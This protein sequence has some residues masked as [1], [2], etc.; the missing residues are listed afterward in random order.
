[1][2]QTIN[3]A[4]GT[5]LKDYELLTQAAAVQKI[6]QAFQQFQI[7]RKTSLG[8]RRQH[9]LTLVKCLQAREDEFAR[10]MA[11]EM[12]KPLES[13]RQ[14]IK[15]CIWVCQHYA[16][17]AENYLKPNIIQT[18]LKKSFVCY[19][20]LGVVLA[21][22]PWNF[23]FWQVFRF[24]APNLMGG[25]VGLLRHAPITT[26]CGEAI[27]ALFLEAGFP[28]HT[29]QHLIIDNDMAAEVIAHEQVAG[30][31]LTGSERAGRAVAANAAAHLKKTVL[32]LGGSDAYVILADADLDK[33]A[34]AIVASRL[35]NSGQTCISAKRVIVVAE[36]MQPLLEKIMQ[37]IALYKMGDPLDPH[38]KLGPMARADLRDTLHHQVI[39]SVAKGAKLLT[40]GTL[41]S[42]PGFYYPITV[43]TKVQPGM[44]A[45]DEELFGP[46]FAMISAKDE[47]QAIALANQSRFGLGSA[48]FTQNVKRGEEIAMH[49]IQAGSCYVNGLVSSDPRL[50]FGGIKHSGYGR[51][52]AKE[53][54][55]EF[56]NVKTVGVHE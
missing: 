53:G 34:T 37:H 54:F 30:V 27:E 32:E 19:E 41:P 17:H 26:G 45:F 2:I 49:E 10:L 20:P 39:A 14:E 36:V 7:W 43:L 8:E 4:T 52:L 55:L 51:E 48:I 42:T 21:I 16:D 13:G 18:E 12:G 56:M 24:A 6:N 3:P 35:N 31:T 5:V 9:M 1:M 50:P 47:S 25:N 29:F 40:G 28:K 11:L 44:P 23:P 15:K 38:T 46:V 33:A 22:M